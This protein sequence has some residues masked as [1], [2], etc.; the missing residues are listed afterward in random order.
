MLFHVDYTKIWSMNKT[1]IMILFSYMN[2]FQCD[3]DKLG[4]K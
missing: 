4:M 2:Y 1:I 3:S